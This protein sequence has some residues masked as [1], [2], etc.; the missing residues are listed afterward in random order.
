MTDK[1]LGIFCTARR[2]MMEPDF[3][4][5]ECPYTSECRKY[6]EKHGYSPIM[7]KYRQKD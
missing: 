7:D 6:R 3:P 4:C 5:I 2:D 1:E